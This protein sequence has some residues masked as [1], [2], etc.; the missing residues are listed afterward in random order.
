MLRSVFRRAV[1]LQ[2]DHAKAEDR[3]SAAKSGNFTIKESTE[4]RIL[5]SG[6]AAKM[7]IEF[8]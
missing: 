8:G 4:N 2:Y 5:G 1:V 3:L 7:T 6:A